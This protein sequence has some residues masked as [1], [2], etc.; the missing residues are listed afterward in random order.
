MSL[1]EVLSFDSRVGSTA[2]EFPLIDDIAAHPSN[3]VEQ[4][5]ESA[6]KIYEGLCHKIAQITRGTVSN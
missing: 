5:Q 1:C 3:L 6:Y 4:D 2:N